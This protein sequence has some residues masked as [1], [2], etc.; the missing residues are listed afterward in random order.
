MESAMASKEITEISLHDYPHQFF[1]WDDKTGLLVSLCGLVNIIMNDLMPLLQ[2]QDR[3]DAESITCIHENDQ[4][5]F[6]NSV[7]KR[8]L[9][10]YNR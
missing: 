2:E 5:L 7:R 10:E 9:K 4:S 8:K 1:H 6:R 3:Q